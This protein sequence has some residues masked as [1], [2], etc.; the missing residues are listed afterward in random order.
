MNDILTTRISPAFL[1]PD[2]GTS[3]AVAEP[4]PTEGTPAPAAAP[5]NDLDI[6]NF[7][8]PDADAVTKALADVTKPMPKPELREKPKEAPKQEPAPKPEPVPKAGAKKEGG[9]PPAAQLRRELDSLKAERDQLKSRLEAGD[10]RVKEIEREIASTRAE[11]EQAKARATE[12]EKKVVL[13]DAEQAPGIRALDQDYDKEAAR[14]YGRVVDAD[15]GVV[16]GLVREMAALPFGSP[17][18][19]EARKAF[20]LKVNE[21]LG[22]SEDERHPDLGATLDFIDK[23]RE[24][25]LTRNEKMQEVSRDSEKYHVEQGTKH[26]QS[27]RQRVDGLIEQAKTIPEGFAETNPLHPR[28]AL[29]KFMAELGDQSAEYDKGIAEFTRLVLAGV[30]PRSSQDFA[31][32]T[33]QQIQEARTEEAHKVEMARDAAAEVIFNGAR[34]LRMFPVLLKELSRLRAKVG[35]DTDSLPPDPAANR[36]AGSTNREEDDI[37]AFKAPDPEQIPNF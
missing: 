24:F 17:E 11:L 32:L 26:Y 35:E 20:N 30:P 6:L 13:R 9:E 5:D 34:A 14:F 22:G 37:A 16:L 1:A 2:T 10:P 28:V 8:P 33:P 15:K 25:L 36:E 18:Y 21:A 12:Y 29:A 7:Q 3:G 27:V 23:T 31:G 4:P 19:K